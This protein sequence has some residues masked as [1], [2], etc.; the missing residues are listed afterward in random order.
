MHHHWALP[1]TEVG[2]FYFLSCIFLS[3]IMDHQLIVDVRHARYG[4][5]A[6]ARFFQLNPMAYF[7]FERDAAAGCV[8]LKPV[9]IQLCMP[10]KVPRDLRL[11]V[12]RQDMAL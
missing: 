2:L 5:S 12:A 10:M 8:H 11:H 7:A 4:Q 9:G 3:C 6:A 1:V